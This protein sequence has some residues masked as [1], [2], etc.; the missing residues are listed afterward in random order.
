LSLAGS[1]EKEVETETIERCHSPGGC[2]TWAQ[3]TE[4]PESS[5]TV[6]VGEEYLSLLALCAT[7]AAPAHSVPFDAAQLSLALVSPL[8]A[9]ALSTVLAYTHSA[10][11]LVSSFEHPSGELHSSS[12]FQRFVVNAFFFSAQ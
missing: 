7:C 4:E 8:L 9:V 3:T 11:A 1:T 12:S 2:C 10:G 5:V 6:A